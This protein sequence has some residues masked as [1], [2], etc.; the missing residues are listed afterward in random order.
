MTKPTDPLAASRPLGVAR[1]LA[2]APVDRDAI[3]SRRVILTGEKCFLE[4]ANGRWCFEDALRLLARTVGE[5]DVVVPDGVPEF[6][7]EVEALIGTMYAQGAVRLVPGQEPEYEGATAILNVGPSARTD[8]PWTAVISNGWVARCSSG[9]ARLPAECRQ[10]NPLGALLAASFGVTEVFKRVYGIPSEVAEP[11]GETAFSL[12]TMSQSFSDV[13]PALP[14]PVI[15]PR[16]LLVGAGAIGNGVVLLASQ[17]PLAGSLSILDKQPFAPENL[18][19]CCIL[20]AQSWLGKSK[21]KMLGGWLQERSQMDVEGIDSTIQMAMQD[22]AFTSKNFDLVINGLDDVTA[23]RDVQKLW[24]SLLVDGAINSIGASVVTHSMDHRNFACMRCTFSEPQVD[25]AAAQ[26]RATGLSQASLN[27][28]ANR[29]LSDVDIDAASEEF[30]PW[31]RDQQRKG[32]TVCSTIASGM[33]ERLGLVF[34]P[35]FRPSVPFVATASAA[36]VMSQVLKGLY[37]R[38]EPFVHEFQFGSLFIGPDTGVR[39]SRKAAPDCICTTKR[40]II[41]EVLAERRARS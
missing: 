21:A 7:R 31:L 12:F 34:S 29:P 19:T 40:H 4:H 30:R 33:A 3:F 23:R 14:E 38:S 37:W 22:D 24:P 26:Q 18:G 2:R 10:S 6:R 1:E 27:G 32:A 11:C 41:D 39:F 35:G 8:L 20:D 16:T 36:L 25:L 9:G 28:D 17:L 15:L 5:L 13:G